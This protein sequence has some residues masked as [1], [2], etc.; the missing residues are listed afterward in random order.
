MI[1]GL[2]CG[3]ALLFLL[4]L[5]AIARAHR[6]SCVA[7]RVVAICSVCLLVGVSILVRVV[8]TLVV[9]LGVVVLGVCILRCRL[10]RRV[11]GREAVLHG[12]GVLLVILGGLLRGLL[13]SSLL[14]LAVDG[15]GGWGGGAHEAVERGRGGGGAFGA[16]RHGTKQQSGCRAGGV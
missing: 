2:R 12:R 13:L 3:E 15:A 4:G 16:L 5:L 7:S 8:V 14:L 11:L 1:S 9:V 10:S 6:G